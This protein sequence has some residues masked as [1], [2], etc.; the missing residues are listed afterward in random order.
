MNY[1]KNMYFYEFLLYL[2]QLEL[3][4]VVENIGAPDLVQEGHERQCGFSLCAAPSQT[5]I[6]I[7]EGSVKRLKADKRD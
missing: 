3:V 5:S 7:Y 2:V 4:G 1:V 6:S